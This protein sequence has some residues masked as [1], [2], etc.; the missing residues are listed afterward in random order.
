[1]QWATT[2][3]GVDQSADAAFVDV[4]TSQSE[5]RHLEAKY[6]VSC[7][8]ASSQTY[9]PFDK[10]GYT[11]AQFFTDRGHWH[12]VARIWTDGL[13][14]VTYGELTG[15]S[16]EELLARQPKKFEL[17]FPGRPKPD[18]GEYKLVRISPY[19]IHQRLAERMRVG[20][21][22]L[23]ADAAH[24]CN[25][26]GGMGLTGG[27][28][29]IGGLYDCLIG[30]FWAKADD[31][32]LDKYD[33]ERRRLYN[34]TINPVSVPGRCFRNDESKPLRCTLPSD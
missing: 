31:D 9:Y 33:Q 29:D 10:Y 20:R 14:R 32:I 34:E 5:R 12:M 25:P 6:V 26:F 8:G 27:I 24:L 30:I 18:S 11:D 17:M 2:V 28:V 15:L 23:A 19:K 13:Y 21:I 4:E 22:L 1:M 3:V 7:D 16:D